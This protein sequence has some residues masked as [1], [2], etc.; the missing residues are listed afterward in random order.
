MQPYD[1]LCE[2]EF[3]C[4]T[5]APQYQGRHARA[6]RGRCHS[7][8]LPLSRNTYEAP[9]KGSNPAM[10]FEEHRDGWGVVPGSTSSELMTHA[11]VSSADNTWSD[12]EV[13]ITALAGGSLDVMFVTAN[14]CCQGPSVKDGIGFGNGDD[15][16]NDEHLRRR[17][18]GMML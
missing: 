14:F 13:L 11:C 1:T 3:S 8:M 18:E 5:E 9:R 4:L 7:F 12:R 17:R 15:L 2:K 6:L 10:H 16:P